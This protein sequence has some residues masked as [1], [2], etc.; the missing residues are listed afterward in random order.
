MISADSDGFML[1]YVTI[2][3]LYEVFKG[4]GCFMLFAHVSNV[5]EECSAL[6]A[7][8]RILLVVDFLDDLEILVWNGLALRVP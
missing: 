2:Y 7:T 1:T 8:V 5:T 6:A 3:S 4:E